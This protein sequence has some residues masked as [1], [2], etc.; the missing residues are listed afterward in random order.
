MRNIGATLMNALEII[1]ATM[2]GNKFTELC[3]SL[4]PHRNIL[5][6]ILLE[7]AD[8]FPS[9]IV[10]FRTMSHSRIGKDQYL[11]AQQLPHIA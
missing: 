6:P 10:R 1:Q 5:T 7:C 8:V 9:Q 2:S 4:Y 11:V 3:L